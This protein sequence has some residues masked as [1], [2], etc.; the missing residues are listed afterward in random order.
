[1]VLWEDVMCG[2]QFR[3]KVGCT[4]DDIMMEEIDRGSDNFREGDLTLEDTME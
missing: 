2:G 4:L 3:E 1:M